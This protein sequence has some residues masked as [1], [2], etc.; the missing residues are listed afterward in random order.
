MAQWERSLLPS[1]TTRV[2]V[3]WIHAERERGLPL[4]VVYACV[5]GLHTMFHYLT[6]ATKIR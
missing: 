2:L 5:L 1:L 4:A 3:S 6:N